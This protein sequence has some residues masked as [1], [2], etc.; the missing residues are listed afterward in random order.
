MASWLVWIIV[1]LVAISGLDGGHRGEPTCTGET[2]GC[3]SPEARWQPVTTDGGKGVIVPE[4]DVPELTNWGTD[5][6]IE[7]SWTP[8]KS[9]IRELESR[10]EAA[11]ASSRSPS[12]GPKPE[13]LQ[14]YVRQY[15]GIIEGGER[16]I[17]VN[18]LCQVDDDSWMSRPMIVLDG[19]NCYFEAI[20]NVEDH[21]FERFQFNGD[22]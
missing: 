14:G 11:A 1:I 4:Q 6:P 8:V 17:Y 22:A 2:S 15:G 20:Y 13:S 12:H 16:K 21:T 5:G 9:D 19:G 7:G 3:G 10:I 18:G